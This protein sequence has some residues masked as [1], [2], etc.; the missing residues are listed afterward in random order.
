MV[1]DKPEGDSFTKTGS[2][3][4]SSAMISRAELSSEAEG[5]PENTE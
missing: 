3:M 2:R 1:S 4:T 5:L